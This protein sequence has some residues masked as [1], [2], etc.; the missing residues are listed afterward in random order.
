[1]KIKH[2]LNS[3]FFIG[4]I[5]KRFGYFRAFTK[6]ATQRSMSEV[7][8]AQE[9]TLIRITGSLFQTEPPHQKSSEA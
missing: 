1:M 3:F 8:V 4:I 6:A 7:V 5:A 2:N 9:H